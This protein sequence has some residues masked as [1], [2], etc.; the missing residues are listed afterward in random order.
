MDIEGYE[1]R[2][3]RSGQAL[4][5]SGRVKLLNPEVRHRWN[6]KTGGCTENEVDA[7]LAD[8]GYRKVFVYNHYPSSQPRCDLPVGRA[9]PPSPVHSIYWTIFGRDAVC[10]R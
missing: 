4:L 1:L 6:G 7:F 8:F 5:R 9:K 10:A 2:A 3:L